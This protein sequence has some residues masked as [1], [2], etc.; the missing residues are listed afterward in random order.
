VSPA[1]SQRIVAHLDALGLHVTATPVDPAAA[2]SA[3]TEARLF[4]FAPEVAD[5]GLA[6]LEAAALAPPGPAV[7]VPLAAVPV[8]VGSRAGLHGVRI[9]A[10]GRVALDDAWL[11]P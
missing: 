5:A 8:S 10:V 3:A 11:E 2:R 7:V 6:T 4:L 1:I 9:D